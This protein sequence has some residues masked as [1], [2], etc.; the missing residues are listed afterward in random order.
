M[1]GCRSLDGL[2]ALGGHPSQLLGFREVRYVAMDARLARPS[3]A[4]PPQSYDTPLAAA[5]PIF[6]PLPLASA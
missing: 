4:R 6:L 1:A 2:G 5:S 3:Q